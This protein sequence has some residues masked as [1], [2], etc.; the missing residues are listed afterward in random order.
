MISVGD[1]IQCVKVSPGLTPGKLYLV[2]KVQGRGF[3]FVRVINDEGKSVDYFL[4]KFR[5]I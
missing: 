4:E 1:Q 3:K 2:N 5:R